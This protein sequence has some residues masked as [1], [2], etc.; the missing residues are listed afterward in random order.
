MARKGQ[1]KRKPWTKRPKVK[2]LP[3]GEYQGTLMSTGKIEVKKETWRQKIER[4][5]GQVQ[6]LSESRD[7]LS[8][9]IEQNRRELDVHRE[10][11]TIIE[12]IFRR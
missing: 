7:R 9:E 8:T 2:P 6:Y 4:L 1:T 3:E 10:Y 11:K 5:E 12:H